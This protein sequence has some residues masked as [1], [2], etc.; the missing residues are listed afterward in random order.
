MPPA[1]AES[2]TIGLDIGGTKIHGVLL[3]AEG[4][5]LASARCATEIGPDGVV[6]G[7]SSLV[8]RLAAEAGIA[9]ADVLSI[10]AGVPGVVDP[11]TGTVSHA[12]NLGVID[13]SFPLAA[14]LIEALGL[15]VVVDNDLNVAALGVAHLTP[16]R[17]EAPL[18]LAFLSIGTGIAA[19]L[20][21]DGVMRRGLGAAGEIGHLPLVPD[22]PVCPCGQRGCLELYGSGSALE[23][24]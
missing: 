23:R 18:D 24:M 13:G 16:E 22:G 11:Q 8:Q 15:P 14:R 3:G 7:T 5:V 20:V 17:G 12:V 19:G 9:V 1:G 6:A 21:L 10:G 2:P 4:K